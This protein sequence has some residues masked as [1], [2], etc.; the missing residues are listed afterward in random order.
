MSLRLARRPAEAAGPR[1][2]V[3]AGAVLLAIAGAALAAPGRP[4]RFEEL[5]KIPRVGGVAVSPDGRLVAYTV[6]TPD[7][8]A[9]T[10]RSAVWIVP[11]A[12]GE[13]RRITSGEKQ[14]GDPRFSPDGKTLA[15]VSDRDGSPQI[16]TVGVSGAGGDASKAT[17]LPTGVNAFSWATRRRLVRRQL[18]RLPRVLRRRV[19]AARARPARRREGPRPG[20]GP[21][22]HPP[23][24]LLEGRDAIAHPAESRRPA[25]GRTWT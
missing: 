18:R 23:L 12:G 6:T 13:A 11:S 5:A 19:P 22:L 16:W 7:V 3:P 10:S 15:F 14:D 4:I 8:E 21:A 24:E 25:A 17:S 1:R 2:F 9:N 20:G